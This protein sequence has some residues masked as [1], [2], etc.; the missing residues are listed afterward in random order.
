MAGDRVCFTQRILCV[1]DPIG[2]SL[3]L[4]L[5]AIYLPA[6]SGQN[7]QLP[8]D[9]PAEVVINGGTCP[10]PPGLSSTDI[11]KVKKFGGEATNILKQNSLIKAKA[12]IED[13]AHKQF[14][15]SSEANKIYALS[16]AACMACRL[17]PGE[18]KACGNLF[19]DI[20]VRA[21]RSEGR[22]SDTKTHDYMNSLVEPL[23]Q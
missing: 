15:G 3:L 16:F 2:T 8:P 22:A 13:N 11:T 17:Q 23:V 6:C 10:I 12:D 9:A 5:F 4:S 19:K 21:I 18:V 14:A 20:V 7:F 1:H